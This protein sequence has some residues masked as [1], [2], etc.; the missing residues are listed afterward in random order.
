MGELLEYFSGKFKKN[1]SASEEQMMKTRVKNAI[2]DLCDKHLKDVGAIFIF[3]VLP[4]DLPYA[5]MV[6]EEEP[7]KSKYVINQIDKT[8]FQ[9]ELREVEI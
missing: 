3:E 7:L 6:I 1:A 5:V 2:S 4:N 9:A 8:L